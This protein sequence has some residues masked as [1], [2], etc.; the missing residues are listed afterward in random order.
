MVTFLAHAVIGLRRLHFEAVAYGDADMSAQA[1][2]RI[3]FAGGDGKAFGIDHVGAIMRVQDLAE[4]DLA[5]APE[6]E[7]EV[8]PAFEGGLRLQNPWRGH[9][10][11]GHC[12]EPGLA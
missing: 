3:Q 11:A 1:R 6:F 12:R 7:R 10:H 9:G 8:T 5:G 4:D 2:D